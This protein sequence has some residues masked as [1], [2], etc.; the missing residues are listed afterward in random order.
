MDDT[1]DQFVSTMAGVAVHLSRDKYDTEEYRLFMES[2]IYLTE[3][4]D[5]MY[6]ENDWGLDEYT[7]EVLM[8]VQQIE[9]ELGKKSN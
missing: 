5:Q 9:K 2:L 6:T 3:V 7:V 1:I 4:E 8:S